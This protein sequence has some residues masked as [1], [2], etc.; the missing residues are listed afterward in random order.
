M[1]RAT[2]GGRGRG[3]ARRGLARALGLALTLAVTA[4]AVGATSGCASGEAAWFLEQGIGQLE[5][6]A[7]ARPIPP[8]L[9]DPSTPEAVRR[10][11]SLV[12]AARKFAR[13]LGLD[14]GFQ[15]RSVVFLDAPAIVYVVTA[16]P[17]TSLDPYTW[18]YPILGALPYRGSFDLDDAEAL[19]LSLEDEGYDVDVRPVTTY[20]LLGAAPDPVLSTML[21]AGDETDL[22]ETVIHEL[23]HATLFVPGQGA[24]NEGLATFIGK[25]G[26]RRFIAQHHGEDSAI[27]RRLVEV[28]RDAD[29]YSRAVGALAFDLRVLFAQRG[30]RRARGGLSEEEILRRKDRIFLEHQ[31][32]WQDEV[33][34]TLLSYRHRRIRLPDNNA[35][36]SAY[37]IY[38][39]KQR[40]Y[41]E[42]WA[43]CR[44][45]MRCFLTV[46]RQVAKE[47]DPEL[48]LAERVRLRH[49]E[50]I[51][52]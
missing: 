11:L 7:A 28:D 37:G 1:L 17:R 29:A 41:Q 43:S 27:A 46:L 34:P 13:E 20:S 8:L 4:P 42:A 22:V 2:S 5:V 25:E 35:E 39:L 30:S 31:R 18:R 14:V 12:V 45:D 50:V 48:A 52:P 44:E 38:S 49:P 36:L 32:H 19:A 23:A 16:A 26:R 21:F 33:A 15:Y 3:A 51:L 6:L 10:R 24:F 40:V 47:P 9:R